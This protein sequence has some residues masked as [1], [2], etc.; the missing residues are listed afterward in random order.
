MRAGRTRFPLSGKIRE[1]HAQTLRCLRVAA[2]Y[3]DDEPDLHGTRTGRYAHALA[4]A[5]GF[6]KTAADD[7]AI[8]MPLHDL[9]KIGIPDAILH[10]PGR[11]TE[12]ERAVVQQHAVI[13]ASI[14]GNSGYG[15]LRLASSIALSHHEKWDG[16]GY[17]HGLSGTA[18]PR[19]ARLAAIVD[20]FDA[21]TSTRAYKPAW[22]AEQA[23]AF[24]GGAGGTHFDPE[25][26]EAFMDCAPEILRLFAGFGVDAASEA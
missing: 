9:G 18:I 3:R 10:K 4:L 16:T 15:L 2:G 22:P 24:I 26:T 17:P 7:L 21:L 25:L 11:L 19:A 14:L 8:T 12:A 13:G 23:I 5:A 20:V 1:A 6:G